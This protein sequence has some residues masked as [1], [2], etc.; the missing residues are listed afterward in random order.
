MEGK[1]LERLT[2]R[3]MTTQTIEEGKREMHNQTL[4]HAKESLPSKA[5][6]TDTTHMV[7]DDRHNIK[8]TGFLQ[9][10]HCHSTV[11]TAH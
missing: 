9:N 7:V 11:W 6:R 2:D 1:N 5:R 10:K 8:N 4:L 3:N